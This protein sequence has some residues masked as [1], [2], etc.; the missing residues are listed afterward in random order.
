MRFS[1]RHKKRPESDWI[2]PFHPTCSVSG[3]HLANASHAQLVQL[4]VG[5]TFGQLERILVHPDG[6]Q[7]RLPN[8]VRRGNVDRGKLFQGLLLGF[9]IQ[10]IPHRCEQRTH[11]LGFLAGLGIQRGEILGHLSS[12][13]VGLWEANCFPPLPFTISRPTFCPSVQ[14]IAT[15]YGIRTY[16]RERL[17]VEVCPISV[18]FPW[19]QIPC[20]YDGNISLIKQCA[21]YDATGRNDKKDTS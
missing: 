14:E 3:D 8:G 16:I 11:R 19:Y 12:P 17:Q 20:R 18:K 1:C 2:G 15:P 4:F 13:L 10:T 5:H 21:N 7:E 9:L 6:I